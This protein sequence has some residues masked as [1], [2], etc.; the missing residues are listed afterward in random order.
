MKRKYA[1]FVLVACMLVVLTTNCTVVTPAPAVEA[2][3]AEPAEAEEM[4]AEEEAAEA[5]EM[6]AEEMAAEAE[7]M[8]AEEEAAEAEE[9]AAEE[10]AAA[11][12]QAVVALTE[13]ADLG[14]FLVDGEGMTLYL[15]TRDDPGVTNCYG[16][17]A[18]AWPPLLTEAGMA[19]VAEEGVTGELSVVEREDGSQQVA[20]NDMPLYYYRDD[21]EPG[22]IV[23]QG[24]GNVWFVLNP[25]PV[26]ALTD[27][28][29]LG[30]FLTDTGGVSLYLFTR[31]DPGVSNCYG[32]CAEA[33]PPLLFGEAGLTPPPGLSG[34]L[35]VTTRT[36]E[37]QQITYNGMPLYYYR[38]DVEPGDIVGQGRGNVWFVVEPAP[39]LA[40]AENA[41]L[42]PILTDLEGMTL[43]LLTR[44][45]PGTSTCYD[46]CAEGWPPV[47]FG[48]AGLTPPRGASGTLGVTTRTDETQQITYNGMPLYYYRDDAE[49]GDVVG[50][51]R[52]DVWFVVNPAPLVPVADNEEL[53]PFFTDS[54]GLTLYLFTNDEPGVS[55]CYDGC[56]EAWPPLLF[57][58]AGL[59]P[60]RGASGTLGITTR[61]DETQQVTYN[62]MPLY[63]YRDDAEPGDVVG[64]GRGE[65]WFVVNPT[66]LVSVAENEEL[67]QFLI[68]SEGLTLYLFTNDEPGVSNCY[69]G[70]A[71]A[72][73]P[74]L[75]GPAGL[76]PA[77]G[78]TGILGITTRTD[79]TQQVT[80]KGMPLYY[81]Q[82]DAE[83]GDVTGQ[84]RGDVWFV[85]E[86]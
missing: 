65:V 75:L 18:E 72:W 35:G 67:G 81:Y 59:T 37:T 55:N 26:V 30:P 11:P 2:P 16:G 25:D 20:Y 14:P 68:D 86:P 57:G 12:G 71:E 60:P 85:V 73:P 28:A 52:G 42:G 8:A 45:R 53:G 38:D 36:D 70:C 84:G 33:W 54:E 22:D 5:E 50:Q 7:E 3:E 62:G 63:Y 83:P 21:V 41:D 4:T 29:D 19:P 56:A 43:Y 17:C 47:L 40:L 74:L 1:L 13:H 6:A 76:T 44:D 15:F 31:D 39:A 80:Y 51:G 69:D 78:L 24:R 32:G 9:M 77:Q 79:E 82:D 58:A 10:E 64:Q 34:T 48:A 46:S 23:G 61:T 66:P 49:P 27:N